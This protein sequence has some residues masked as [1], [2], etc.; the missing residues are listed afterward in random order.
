MSDLQSSYF[1]LQCEAERMN[2]QLELLEKS[3]MQ[4]EHKI[5]LEKLQIE[6]DDSEDDMTIYSQ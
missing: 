5:Q 3:I 1:F 4:L 6:D 2:Q